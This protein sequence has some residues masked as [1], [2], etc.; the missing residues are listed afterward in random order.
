MYDIHIC[1]DG[2]FVVCVAEPKLVIQMK[3]V[4]NP[5]PPKETKQLLGKTVGRQMPGPPLALYDITLSTNTHNAY[6]HA[7]T[8]V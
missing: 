2:F 5:P 3:G 4:A 6:T 1:S 7:H 8:Q